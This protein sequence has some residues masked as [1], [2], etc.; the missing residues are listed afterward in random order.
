MLQ[1][2]AVFTKALPIEPKMGYAAKV[3]SKGFEKNL[4]LL[5]DLLRA[6]SPISNGVRWRSFSQTGT[7]WILIAK[8]LPGIMHIIRIFRNMKTLK[9]V[10]D[11][12]QKHGKFKT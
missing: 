1:F 8:G 2:F 5:R 10:S 3:V 6:Y 7:R 11:N 4:E 12:L 9:H